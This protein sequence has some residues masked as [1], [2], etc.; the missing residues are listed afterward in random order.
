MDRTMRVVSSKETVST[1]ATDRVWVELVG[2]IIVA[3]IR[4]AA[5]TE[6]VHECQ[7]RV[8]A[9]QSDTGCNR[10]LYD[11]LEL[12][13]P[14][15]DLVLAQRAMTGELKHAWAKIAIVVPN[16]AIAYLSRL[17]FGDANHRVFYNDITAAILWLNNAPALS[18]RQN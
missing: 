2:G 14:P 4:G 8:V 5:T 11:A 12:E 6:L 18:S 15:I 1:P 7:K 3:R 10:I 16:T 13:R 17:A 9:L